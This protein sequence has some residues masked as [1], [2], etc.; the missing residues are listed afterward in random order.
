MTLNS[1]P[2]HKRIAYKQARNVVLVSLVVG[3]LFSLTQVYFDFQ[4]EKATFD[5]TIK[6][7]VNTVHQPAARAAYNLE[8]DLAAE[9]AQGLFEFNAI[10]EVR[11]LDN[12][13]TLITQQLRPDGPETKET[14]FEYLRWLTEAVF[15]IKQEYT[16]SLRFAEDASV[17]AGEIYVVADT[18][19]M[20][21]H[22]YERSILVMVFGLIRNMVLA[23]I[24][25]FVFYFFL[26]KPL[27]AMAN[28]LSEADPNNPEETLLVAPK[29]NKEDEFHQ[30]VEAINSLLLVIG[31]RNRE[32]DAAERI[33]R[34]TSLSL[35]HKVK[36]RTAALEKSRQAAEAA[37]EAKSNFLATMS[38]EIRTPLNGVLGVAQLLSDSDLSEDQTRKVETIMS[39][40]RTLLSIINDV[41]DMS[42][43]EAGS[44]EVE[45]RA[46]CLSEIISTISSPFQNLADEKGL[47]LSVQSEVPQDRIIVGDAIR[48]RQILWNLLS[49][50]IKFT[51]AGYVLLTIKPV[52]HGDFPDV[53]VDPV[54]E[55]LYCFMIKDTGAGISQNRLQSIF[56]PFTQEDE[57]ITRKFGGTGL[58]LSIVKELVA[59][60][61]GEIR[62]NSVAG[63]GAA[64]TVLLP[65]TKALPQE[66]NAVLKRGAGLQ[67]QNLPSI[68]V[69]IAEDNEVNALIAKSFLEK[70]G[71]TVRH[72]VNGKRAVEVAAEGWPDMIL[73]DIHMPEMDGIEATRAI[74]ATEK[75]QSIP[76][77]G[78]TAEAFADRHEIFKKAG[79][80][81]ILTKPYTEQQ[82]AD[83]MAAN[84]LIERRSVARE[85]PQSEIRTVD[86]P[87]VSESDFASKP[88]QG[89]DK[90]R[91]GSIEPKNADYDLEKFKELQ[92]QLPEEAVTIL[93]GEAQKSL[94]T[95]L[96]E[97]RESLEAEDPRQV[98]EAAHAIKGASGSMFAV[99]VSRLAA[100]IEMFSADILKV[101]DMMPEFETAAED[102]LEWWQNQS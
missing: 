101:Q 66:A 91:Q 78:V 19:L 99:R 43:I 64:F 37:S 56:D 16:I 53:S 11:I 20:A 86:K 40:G 15:G 21:V 84:R 60:M 77:I 95:R 62:A 61:R 25:S 58:G 94:R 49:N 47:V 46:F 80:A 22:L 38:H 90:P 30:L 14:P 79:M 82:L 72:V 42:K 68:N 2:F 10:I 52:P 27:S 97:L 50:A 12:I 26:A 98:R 28:T 13:G 57:T 3:L 88:L 75:G 9:V 17:K 73:M 4:T 32:R 71:H 92:T 39:S 18:H 29:Q 69:L 41:L 51:D 31:R 65:F 59:L 93:I 24:L 45:E 48:L 23:V 87:N 34:D 100:D 102:A 8:E 85:K 63:E 76:I 7:V 89:P 70:F 6:Q 55:D 67:N 35:E 1:I 54:K 74:Q 44:L 96:N 81:D 36:E 5:D 83:I 33:L